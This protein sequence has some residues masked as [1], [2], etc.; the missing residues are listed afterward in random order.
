[1]IDPRRIYTASVAQ[2]FE[3]IRISLAVSVGVVGAHNTF[4]LSRQVGDLGKDFALSGRARRE[5]APAAGLGIKNVS[6][7]ALDLSTTTTGSAASYAG[8]RRNLTANMHQEFKTEN[9]SSRY[10]PGDIFHTDFAA[11]E[12]FGSAP[13]G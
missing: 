13:N 10:T 9:T 3:S 7:P 11:A 12:T 8:D 1:M 6:A 4:I 5:R 2:P